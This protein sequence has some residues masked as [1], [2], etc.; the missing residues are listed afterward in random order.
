VRYL[1]IKPGTRISEA[2]EVTVGEEPELTPEERKRRISEGMK[3]FHR[4]KKTR[5]AVAPLKPALKQTSDGLLE[6]LKRERGE[7]DA[8]IAYLERRK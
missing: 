1:L 8:V 6:Q 5:K 4:K 7:L 3:R 2:K